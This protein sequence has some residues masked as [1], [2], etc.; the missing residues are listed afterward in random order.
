[1]FTEVAL[2]V[3]YVT[4]GT[5]VLAW[6]RGGSLLLGHIYICTFCQ[7]LVAI[8]LVLWAAMSLLVTQ[9]V[10]YF[11]HIALQPWHEVSLISWPPWAASSPLYM[12]LLL[13]LLSSYGLPPTPHSTSSSWS[14]YL[15]PSW[16]LVLIIPLFKLCHYFLNFFH[17]MV[18]HPSFANNG[19]IVSQESLLHFL[20][21]SLWI[22]FLPSFESGK[23]LPV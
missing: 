4:K 22:V 7:W 2:F 21:L 11:Q 6:I 20:L 1:M 9:I 13:F 12:L 23:L 18:Y 3:L 17:S 15:P 14:C 19:H 8:S 5:F 16:N 10:L